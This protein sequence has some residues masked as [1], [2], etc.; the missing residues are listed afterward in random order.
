MKSLSFLT[1]GALATAV[2]ASAHGDLIA[3]WTILAPLPAGQVGNN[4]TM[5]AATSGD[6]TA[7]SELSSYHALAAATYSTPAGNGSTYSF[8]SNNWSVG[9]YYQ[10]SLNASNYTELNVSWDQARSSTGPSSFQMSFSTD[11]GASWTTVSAYTVLQTGGTGSPGTW[12]ATGVYNPVYT[13]SFGLAGADNAA[14]LI[15]RFQC[16]A[17]G[18][19]TG[20]TNRIDNITISGNLVPAPGALALLG[21]AGL[22][23][24]RRR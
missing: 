15:I 7:G 23:S 8:S 3:G 11:G 21:V 24:R 4:Y 20:G 22:S 2:V 19:S 1:V 16:L 5:G 18:S 10:V 13:S 12:S 9:D 14:S 6:Q 17:A